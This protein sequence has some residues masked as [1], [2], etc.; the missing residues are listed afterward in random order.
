MDVL[1]AMARPMAMAAVVKAA[2]EMGTGK[3]ETIARPKSR[4]DGGGRM[5]VVGRGLFNVKTS[6]E[7]YAMLYSEA[8]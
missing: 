8:S 4:F 1:M 5:C 7:H 3:Y 2:R 6:Y